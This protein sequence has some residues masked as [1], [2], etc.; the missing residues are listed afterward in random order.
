MTSIRVTSSSRNSPACSPPN[1]EQSSKSI[2]IT[3]KP[4]REAST[5]FTLADLPPRGQR[6]TAPPKGKLIETFL[7]PGDLLYIPR[8]YN[9]VVG[10]NDAHRCAVH[11]M[12]DPAM[13]STDPR[14]PS[15][16]ASQGRSGRARPSRGRLWT[17]LRQGD[18]APPEIFA[19]RRG[20]QIL[21]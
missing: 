13:G 16:G 4:N 11:E 12:V 2:C 5:F 18:A 17:R 10:C 7:E 6:P 8:G 3:H 19:F 14:R 20:M 21:R 15:C 1:R 9:P